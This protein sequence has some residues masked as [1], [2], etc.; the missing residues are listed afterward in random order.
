MN[1]ARVTYL[2]QSFHCSFVFNFK[3]RFKALC[4]RST[5]PTVCGCFRLACS[6][7]ISSIFVSSCINSETKAVPRSERIFD[8]IQLCWKNMVVSARATL[9]ARPFV[10]GTAKRY[11][12]KTSTAVKTYVYIGDFKGPTKS[13]CNISPG[14]DCKDETGCNGVLICFVAARFNCEH[15]KQFRT[16][17]T[18]NSV[19]LGK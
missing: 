5:T 4:D 16:V 13:I 9:S 2:C 11:L 18:K 6:I 1:V 17:D 3:I 8:G 14:Q 15:C 7:Q 12:L 19:K 10:S